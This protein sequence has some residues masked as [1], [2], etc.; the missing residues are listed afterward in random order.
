MLNDKHLFQN[1]IEI[2]QKRFGAEIDAATQRD[3]KRAAIGKYVPGG[4]S[5]ENEKE[6]LIAEQ[7]PGLAGDD[8]AA[9]CSHHPKRL[10]EEGF[11][12]PVAICSTPQ[13]KVMITPDDPPT[14]NTSYI[15]SSPFSADSEEFEFEKDEQHMNY[16]VGPGSIEWVLDRNS[17]RLS[18]VLMNS[19]A[20]P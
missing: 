12:T 14:S 9:G 19:H 8:D 5:D 10:D 15:P 7:P 18:F 20:R 1:V 4:S 17:V 13:R 2:R 3:A 11:T 6:S 16:L